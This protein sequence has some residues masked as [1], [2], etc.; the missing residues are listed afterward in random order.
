MLH[1]SIHLLDLTA[2]KSLDPAATP[3]LAESRAH[4]LGMQ[5]IARVA[6]ALGASADD[7]ESMTRYFLE[8]V[9]PLRKAE[10][11]DYWSPDCKADGP[12]DQ[13]PDDGVWP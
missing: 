6:V 7:A 3:Q 2:G 1:E 12:L 10:N 8:R 11:P 9:Y 13:T 5:I 4:C